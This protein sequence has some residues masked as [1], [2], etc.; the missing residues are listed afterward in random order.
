MWGLLL[1][2]G[3]YLVGASPHDYFQARVETTTVA[4]HYLPQKG[5][6][7]STAADTAT[8]Q[9][10][11][12]GA[13]WQPI[14]IGYELINAYGTLP[15]VPYQNLVM[16]NLMTKAVGYWSSVLKVR[17]ATAPL[18]AARATSSCSSY[19]F[20]PTYVCETATAPT[21]GDVTI[22]DKYL[23]STRTVAS[24]CSP[25]LS[26]TGSCKSSSGGCRCDVSQWAQAK[27]SYCC[28]FGGRN[29]CNTTQYAN[30]NVNNA[31]FI[32]SGTSGGVVCEAGVTQYPEGAGATNEDL[33]IFVTVADNADCKASPGSLL[34]YAQWCVKD[35][36][37]RPVFG[38]IHFCL[39][40]L[41]LDPTDESK[42]IL[43]AV[44]ELTHAMVFSSSLFSF[45]RKP[46]GTPLFART[47][48]DD[49][50]SS[51]TLWTCRSNTATF[52]SQNGE[53]SWVDITGSNGIA[54]VMSER[55]M[56]A[57]GCQKVCPFTPSQT[58][59]SAC[60]AP[61]SGWI[62]AQCVV[63][64]T[65][66]NVQREAQNFFG[67]STLV[68][69]ELEN[70]D[71]SDC[72]IVASHW[73]ERAFNGE[74]MVPVSGTLPFQYVSTVT[75]ALFHDS[76][77]YLPDYTQADP[78]TKGVHWG[79]QQ[80][81][82][83]ATQLCVSG[84]TPIWD[85]AFCT[86]S[87]PDSCSLDR[88]SVMRCDAAQATPSPQ[89]PFK[90]FSDSTQGG[91]AQLDY[92]PTFRTTLS[93]RVCT[94]ASGAYATLPYN[95]NNFMREAVGSSSRCLSST[96]YT[97]TDGGAP[98][99]VDSTLFTTPLATCYQVVCSADGSSYSVYIASSVGSQRATV[100]GP[101]ELL[102]N[103]TVTG[104]T[105]TKTGF[106]GA[107]TC[108]PVAELCGILPLKSDKGGNSVNVITGSVTFT[109]T[110]DPVALSKSAPFVA[111]VGQ[112][113]ATRCGV[114]ASW[115][116]V[117][118]SVNSRRLEGE[119]D[120]T[121]SDLERRLQ[122]SITANYAISIPASST[123]SPST[124]ASTLSSSTPAQL[125]TS[126][127]SQLTAAGLA[128]ITVTTVQVA[129][130]TPAPTYAPVNLNSGGGSSGGGGSSTTRSVNAS[131]A[132]RTAARSCGLASTLLALHLALQV[133]Q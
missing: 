92:C 13:T 6:S 31:A 102:G 98:F 18:K 132:S 36:C 106:N 118:L 34:A 66:T 19:P 131:I 75:L 127:N 38:T 28:T 85:R 133:T 108:A 70:Q 130:T 11:A 129:T 60:L 35:Q 48:V 94:D 58:M 68:G 21:C 112:G 37:D 81:C 87:S 76:G 109:V 42:Q 1:L 4:Q 53:R 2:L 117:T 125:S 20:D 51:E 65:M 33:H 43:T 83:F 128:T 29:D 62:G 12:A 67:C 63:R 32:G 55:G 54:S 96:F 57:A 82:N 78:L 23:Q 123:V 104:Q 46:D 22:P 9:Q 103:C 16:G 119:V 84:N 8:C 110:G 7:M 3:A 116:N 30:C 27:S 121:G 40:A 113:I 69:P 105:L 5:R 122:S 44:H 97:S 101:T 80:G 86:P 59:T 64:L 14:R 72:T 56:T 100:T 111:A 26:C 126:I 79:Y 88:R 93:N 99:K 17:R 115:V 49:A 45:Y 124:V 107:V 77:W 120:L 10:V 41:S 114:N 89:A 71:T 90:Y 25:S 50:F 24:R 95:S 73:E 47:N 39:N 61:Q 52:P 91:V 74:L 15:P